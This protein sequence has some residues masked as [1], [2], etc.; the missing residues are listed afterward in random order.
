M[1][2][3]SNCFTMLMLQNS[4]FHCVCLEEKQLLGV[5]Q[6]MSEEA[7]DETLVSVIQVVGSNAESV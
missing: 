7:A 6:E 1:K 5:V 4:A 3:D 2:L